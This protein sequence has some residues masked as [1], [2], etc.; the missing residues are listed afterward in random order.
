VREKKQEYVRSMLLMELE[1]RDEE[2]EL[3]R[4]LERETAAEPSRK[5]GVS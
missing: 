3:Q 4:R 1:R 2:Q 5:I